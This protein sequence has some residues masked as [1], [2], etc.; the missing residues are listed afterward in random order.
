[1]MHEQVKI[2][3]AKQC[4]IVGAKYEDINFEDDLWFFERQ[5]T[6]EQESEFIDWLTD[7]LRTNKEARVAIMKIP[8][9][10]KSMCKRTAEAF[11][12]NFGWKYSE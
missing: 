2:V 6:K 8:S 3:L 11:A 9:R 12:F 7:H 10:T 1:M 4:E 5:W